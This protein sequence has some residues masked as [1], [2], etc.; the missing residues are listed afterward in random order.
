MIKKLLLLFFILIVS[1]NHVIAQSEFVFEHFNVTSDPIFNGNNFRTV[2][3]G[4]FGKIWAGSQYNGIVKYD[5]VLKTW[6]PSF[7]LSN[8]PVS[9][10][11]LDLFKRQ[12]LG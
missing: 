4:R 12:G 2:A 9:Y 10:T 8:V 1:L 11:L 7:D 5:P 3:V 6:R